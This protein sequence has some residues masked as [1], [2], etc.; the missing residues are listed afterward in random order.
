MGTFP[1]EGDWIKAYIIDKK[2]KLFFVAA[3]SNKTLVAF[4]G[5][6]GGC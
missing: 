3:V 4:F 6:L 5:Y 1:I 2:L